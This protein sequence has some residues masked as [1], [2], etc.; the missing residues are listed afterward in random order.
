MA[1]QPAFSARKLAGTIEDRSAV[2]PLP[3]N[4]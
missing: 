1:S 2:P 4:L 3:L